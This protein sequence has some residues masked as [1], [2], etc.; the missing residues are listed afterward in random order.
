[1]TRRK[2]LVM[3]KRRIISFVGVLLIM[4]IMVTAC[5]SAKKDKSTAYYDTT[6]TAKDSGTASTSTEYDVSDKA[7]DDTT[8]V[9]MQPT[10]NSS[11]ESEAD[12][13]GNSSALTSKQLQAL[14]QE[15]I[16]KNF[17]LEVETKGFDTLIKKINEKINSLGGYVESSS[18]DGNSYYDGN[19]TRSGEIVARIPSAKAD[20]FVSTVG[21]SANV[22][23]NESSTKNVTLE[24]ID[25]QS[26]IKTLKI[27][28]DRLFAILEKTE[29]LE[30]I[31]TLESRL[32][33]IRY[34]LQN[35]ESQLRSYDNKVEYSTVRMSIKEVERI[36]PVAKKKPT[37]SDRI[38]DGFSNTIYN[39]SEGFKNF[40]VWLIVNL[41]Y[42]LIW[43]VVILIAVIVI[44]KIIKKYDINKG[45]A[46]TV[47]SNNPNDH[48]SK[49]IDSQ[50]VENHMT[51]K[52]DTD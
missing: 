49:S 12:G 36:K 40:L 46:A 11:G 16:I 39:I 27:E 24:Y 19:V 26:R 44:R 45:T 18:I 8:D 37:F 30:S 28:Q 41:P 47:S 7:Q 1:M 14:T 21:E 34:E 2:L 51:D 13:I 29:K 31:I 52:K 5:A 3:K 17:N 20:E 48:S 25:A 9:E 35:Y 4:V 38:S 43:G 50:E 10:K 15:K 32:S 22:I 33:E 23:N 6:D 42:L